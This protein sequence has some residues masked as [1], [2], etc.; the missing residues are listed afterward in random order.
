MLLT[1]G[2]QVATFGSTVVYW[3]SQRHN[4]IELSLKLGSAQVQTLLAACR[5]FAMV[6]ISD[7]GPGWNV[8]ED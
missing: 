6:R 8:P 1:L 7:S 2:N 3:L 5:R 4:F